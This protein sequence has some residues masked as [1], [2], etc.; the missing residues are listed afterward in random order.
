[1]E[2]NNEKGVESQPQIKFLNWYNHKKLWR[3]RTSLKENNQAFR[4]IGKR[5]ERW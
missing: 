1:V 3:E 4:R 5:V 2:N